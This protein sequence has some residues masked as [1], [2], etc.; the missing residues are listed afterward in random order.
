MP[1]IA[2]HLLDIVY[3]SI[4]ALAKNIKI[5]IED[6]KKENKIEIIIEDDGKGMDEKTIQQ[7]IDPFFTTRTTRHVGLGV[8][9]FKAG[10]EATGGSFKI[11]SKVDKGTII[12]AIYIKDHIDT[13]PLGNLAETLVTLIQADE[14]I[15]YYFQYKNDDHEFIFDTKQIKEILE[16]VKI[17][18]PEIILWLKDYIKEGVNL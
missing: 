6:L 1:D 18:D 15:D 2:M 13:P 8:P 9:L 5:T 10:V 11:T 16:N 4:R 7:V 17:N 12:H 14:N 3:N